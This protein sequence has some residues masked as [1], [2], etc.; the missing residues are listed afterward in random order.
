MAGTIRCDR[1]AVADPDPQGWDGT[2]ADGAPPIYPAAGLPEA[3]N[4]AQ[5]S[6]AFAQA[7]RKPPRLENGPS[8][9]RVAVPNPDGE[10]KVR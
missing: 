6:F 1:D 4:T 10:E 3:C 8:A 9:L 7:P 5:F 2:S